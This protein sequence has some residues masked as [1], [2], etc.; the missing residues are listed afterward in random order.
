MLTEIFTFLFYKS[1]NADLKVKL[2]YIQQL[3]A[4]FEKLL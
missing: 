4:S 2:C 3:N 1:M